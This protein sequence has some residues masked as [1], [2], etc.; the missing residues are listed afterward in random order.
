MWARIVGDK[1]IIFSTDNDNVYLDFLRIQL[2]ILL[3]DVPIGVQRA[4]CLLQDGA[5]SLISSES[6]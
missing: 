1:L 2:L 6:S 5:S 3:E 4:M